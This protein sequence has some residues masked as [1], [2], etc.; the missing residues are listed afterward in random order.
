MNLSIPSQWQLMHVPGHALRQHLILDCQAGSESEIASKNKWQRV[1]LQSWR[2]ET[3][4]TLINKG[5]NKR[6]K[7]DIRQSESSIHLCRFPG[8]SRTSSVVMIN[9]T[10]IQYIISYMYDVY[11]LDTKFV[12]SKT[13]GLRWS[14]HCTWPCTSTSGVIQLASSHQ[15]RMSPAGLAANSP[16]STNHPPSFC[17]RQLEHFLIKK[18]IRLRIT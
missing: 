5:D 4:E 11:T 2:N 14:A 15:K 6:I 1:Q 17:S 10:Y 16:P 9:I 18:I 13:L 12:P 3:T 7:R 8:S